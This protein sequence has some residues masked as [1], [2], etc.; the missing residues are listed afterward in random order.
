MAPTGIKRA[1]SI[2]ASPGKRKAAR[3]S[4]DADSKTTAVIA[5]LKHAELPASARNLLCSLVK[6]S[7]GVYKAERHPHQDEVVG[8]VGAELQK[9]KATLQSAVEELS[10]GCAD[11]FAEKAARQAA[12]EEAEKRLA[13]AQLV[14][15]E[16]QTAASADAAALKAAKQELRL[17]QGEQSAGNADLD[18]ALAK[19]TK[20]EAAIGAHLEVLRTEGGGKQHVQALRALGKT[21][22]FES[23]MLTSLSSWEAKKAPEQRGDFERVVLQQLEAEITK[24]VAALEKT[25]ADGEAGKAERAAKVATAEAA[26]EAATAQCESSKAA[27][28]EAKAAEKTAKDAVSAAKKAVGSFFSDMKVRGDAFDEAKLK[29]KTFEEGPMAFFGELQVLA[30]PPE[31]P[32]PEVPEVPAAPSAEAPASAEAA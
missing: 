5:A 7:L 20:L 11:P 25:L 1:A 28:A 27:L 3:T 4:A 14:P 16:R 21:F 24:H 31:A 8:I 2:A 22:G 23:S 32:E 26:V 29:L 12:L 6:H 10:S 17:A 18:D 15:P 30:P 9:V 13:E 19:K